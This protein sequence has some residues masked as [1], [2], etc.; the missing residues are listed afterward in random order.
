M[1]AYVDPFAPGRFGAEMGHWMCAKWQPG[2]QHE[3]V[4]PPDGMSWF[5]LPPNETIKSPEIQ[6]FPT[7]R[8]AIKYLMGKKDFQDLILNPLAYQPDPLMD[9]IK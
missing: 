4:T 6:W 3:D 8:K 2:K 1:T 5:V 9:R 7:G